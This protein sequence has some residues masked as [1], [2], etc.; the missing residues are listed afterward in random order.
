MKHPQF[1][2]GKKEITALHIASGALIVSGIALLAWFFVHA[3]YRTSAWTDE[4]FVPQEA[5]VVCT[6]RVI[7]G[8]CVTPGHEKPK[9]MAVMIE[10]HLDARPQSGLSRAAVV[11]E[12]PV[13]GNYSR[14][15]AIF[16]IYEE[17]GKVGPVRSARPYFLDWA[18]EFGKPMY[19]HVGGSPDALQELRSSAYF[20]FNEFSRGSYFWRSRDRYAPHNVYTSSEEWTRGWEDFGSDAF[21]FS[22]ESWLYEEVVP[23]T[24]TCTTS[25]IASFAPPVYQAEWRYS[26]TTEKYTRYQ[27]KKP[28]VDQDGTQISANTV[29]VQYVQTKVL[30]AELRIEMDTVGSGKAVVFTKGNKVEGTWKKTNR[31]SKTR[32]YDS[33][34]AEIPF[35][36]G[37]IWIEAVNQVGDAEWK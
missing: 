36:P 31:D 26:T 5:A 2:I 22:E 3:N 1:F 25:I 30:D 29:V 27:L 28:H 37:K 8:E 4:E 10:N 13:E 14:F 17:V 34:G 9:L 32:F 20:D 12:A 11:Y 23:C 6:P 16:P 24:T 18:R 35:T 21:P 7:D 19:M 33:S 15:M